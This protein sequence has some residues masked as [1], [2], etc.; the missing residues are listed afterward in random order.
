MLVF[1]SAFAATNDTATT[2]TN[3]NT[4]TKPPFQN[5]IYDGTLDSQGMALNGAYSKSRILDIIFTID[6]SQSIGNIAFNKAKTFISSLIQ[7]QVRTDAI[8]IHPDY[9]WMS[10][11]SFGKQAT[12]IADGI[13]YGTFDACVFEE[14][15]SLV[16][17][18]NSAE[19]NPA[20]AFERAKTIFET[21][22]QKGKS[23]VILWVFSDGEDEAEDIKR[24][25]AIEAL[26]ADRVEVFVVGVGAWLNS[27]KKDENLRAIA[28]DCDH[29]LCV[30]DWQEVVTSTGE[31]KCIKW[32]KFSPCSLKSSDD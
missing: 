14:K 23:K 26:R 18:D 25:D 10:L 7:Y 22:P 4:T 5:C 1:S 32:N 9:S 28:T 16:K 30:D 21:S 19:P 24:E 2:N 27:A 3:T 29:Y 11:M 31:G 13:K 17:L 20:N 15:L 8:T 12:V 6:S